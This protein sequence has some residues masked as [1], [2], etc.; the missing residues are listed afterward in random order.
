LLNPRGRHLVLASSFC[1]AISSAVACGSD[2]APT[3]PEEDAGGPVADATADGPSP[4]PDE[5]STPDAS[6]DTD[7][8]TDAA[9]GKDATTDAS[10]GG[11]DAGSGPCGADAGNTCAVGAACS[12]SSDCEGQCTGN[13]CAAPTISDGKV[14]PSLGET[15][16]DCGGALAKKCADALK[17]AKSADC[18]S[19]ACSAL[20]KRCVAGP[21]CGGAGGAAGVETCGAGETGAVGTT[22]ESCCKSLPL[23]VRTTRRLDRYEITA[24][25]VRAFLEGLKPLHAG[26]PNVRAFAKAFAAANPTSELGRVATDYP[27]LLDVLPDT[28]GTGGPVPL[29]V[30]LGAFPLD[31]INSLDGCY[32]GKDA[33]GHP[34]YFQDP[35]VLKAYGEGYPDGNGVPD[36]KR[37]YS[38]DELDQKPMNCVMP[39]MLAAF[40]AWDGGELARTQDY[41]EVWGSRPKPVGAATVYVPWTDALAVGQFNW[42]N[43]HGTTCNPAFAG[44]QNPQL[45]FYVFP[46]LN[47]AG[48][49]FNAADDQ[50]PEIG[51]PGR[52]PLDVT[53]AKSANGEGWFDIGGNLM[54]AAWPV[55][56][57]NPG[58]SAPLDVCDTSATA[59]GGDVACVR[60]GKAGVRRWAGLPPQVA[61]VG[62]SFEG[63]ARRTEAY[64]SAQVAENKIATGDLKPV[65][66][67]YGKI[68]G[69]CAR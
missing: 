63:H 5:A 11:S 56:V 26:Q 7:G 27:G 64:V 53:H 34:T 23:P 49:A 24:G 32:V 28:S 12:S 19:T 57:V 43:G 29:P 20:T 60:R 52:F 41:R 9:V 62:Y 48:A 65:H 8:G 15:D 42:R 18:A 68:G 39:L 50:S 61:L 44:C 51:S 17:C 33:Y 4:T 13:T 37:K 21:S 2:V 58:G 22:H 6:G 46:A 25:R 1:L 38:K 40:C 3:I 45:N 35:A 54:E 30:H 36:G 16:V 59:A 47:V 31:P 67:Q 69:R 10:D 66:F 14:S 55:G